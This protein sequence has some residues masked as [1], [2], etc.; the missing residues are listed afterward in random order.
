MQQ[1][2]AFRPTVVDEGLNV[3]F[4]AIHRVFHLLVPLLSSIQARLE[5]NKLLVNLAVLCKNS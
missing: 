3:L 2:C 4:Q 1:L 5:L